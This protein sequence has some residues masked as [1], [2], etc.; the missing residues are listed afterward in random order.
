[1]SVV[2]SDIDG[3]DGILADIGLSGFAGD[4]Q[5]ILIIDLFGGMIEAES[6]SFQLTETSS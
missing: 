1:M 2:D 6:A 5:E 3:H 4:T